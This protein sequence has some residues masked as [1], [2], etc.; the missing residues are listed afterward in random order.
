MLGSA[1]D[2]RTQNVG[3]A[4]MSTSAS[5]QLPFLCAFHFFHSV[6]VD[7]RRNHRSYLDK[8][9][10][11]DVPKKALQLLL[12]GRDSNS[13]SSARLRRQFCANL[14]F[15]VIITIELLPGFQHYNDPTSDCIF[16]K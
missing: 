11:V 13:W 16:Q 1:V 12:G 5:A 3:R 7:E 6:A 8:V 14:F 4:D 2:G 10:F 15:V 9:G